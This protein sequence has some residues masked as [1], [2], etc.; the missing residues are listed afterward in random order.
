MGY[1]RDRFYRFKER[2]D[3]GGEAALQELTRRKPI[4]KNRVAPALEATIVALAL[5]EPA[6]GQLRVANELAKQGLTISPAGVR[7][8]WA[9][10]D[11]QTMVVRLKALE[12]TRAR[13][14]FFVGTL[15]GVGRIYP[16]T[17]VDTYSKVPFAK[18]YQ[19]KTPVTAA[20]VPVLRILTDRGTEFCGVLDRH[21]TNSTSRWRTLITRRCNTRS[22]T[23]SWSGSRRRSTRRWRR[24]RPTRTP[25]W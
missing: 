7:C 4:L 3:T 22:R 12:A 6:W 5:A 24:C 25:S 18:L 1:S 10:H 20:G 15:K 11:L 21:P 19:D 13:D 2:D 9:R 14:T 8:V 16:Q 23:G 17:F